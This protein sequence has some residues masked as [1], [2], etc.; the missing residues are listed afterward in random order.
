MKTENFLCPRGLNAG[1]YMLA[2]FSLSVF[3]ILTMYASIALP[4][5]KKIRAI[6]TP[7]VDSQ[8][9]KISVIIITRAMFSATPFFFFTFFFL[10]TRSFYDR[11]GK[12]VLTVCILALAV[13]SLFIYSAVQTMQRTLG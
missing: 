1:Y 3:S 8:K 6:K 2:Q 13:L 7:H 4:Y 5:L 9:K 12:N 11:C 10:N